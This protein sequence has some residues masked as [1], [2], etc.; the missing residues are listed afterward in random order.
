ML[1]QFEFGYACEAQAPYGPK[2]RKVPVRKPRTSPV[3][4]KAPDDLIAMA[5][6]QKWQHYFDGVG[7]LDC[8]RKA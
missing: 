2:Q 7:L 8:S 5:D 3:K 6:A 1:A 4:E